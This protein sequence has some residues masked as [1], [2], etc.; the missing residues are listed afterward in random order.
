MYCSVCAASPPPHISLFKFYVLFS[1]LGIGGGDVN[2]S[3]LQSRFIYPPFPP[4]EYIWAS[5]L[6]LIIPFPLSSDKSVVIPFVNS[7]SR[8]LCQYLYIFVNIFVQ[9]IFIFL[10]VQI[11]GNF[12]R[13]LRKCSDISANIFAQ[14]STLFHFWVP[15]APPSICELVV[16]MLC[17]MCLFVNL[18]HT[19]I[20]AYCS[21]IC[22]WGG[23]GGWALPPPFTP[24]GASCLWCW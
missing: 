24:H 4:P 9:Y 10:C 7:F 2:W 17:S 13:T 15:S 22:G 3:D 11:S 8:T 12:S 21:M 18:A 16:M 5:L 20:L 19:V 23:G 6:S 1:L 14:L